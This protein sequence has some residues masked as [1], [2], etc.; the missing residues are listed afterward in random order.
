MSKYQ[1]NL[2]IYLQYKEA[3]GFYK[4][5]KKPKRKIYEFK[6]GDKVHTG[7]R[8]GLYTVKEVKGCNAILTVKH[9]RYQ[10]KVDVNTLTLAG[11]GW[12]NNKNKKRNGSK[13]F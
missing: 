5:R 1:K 3:G 11:G 4:L 7:G 13:R 10:F 9:E 2:E 12:N 6:P 8:R